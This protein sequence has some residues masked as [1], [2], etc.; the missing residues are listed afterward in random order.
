[1]QIN[2]ILVPVDFSECS[3]NA[4]KI[5]IGFAK[6]FNAKIHMVNAVHVHHPHP[7]FVG[8]SLIDSI[9]LDYENQV[10]D[11]FEELE[12][13][14]IELKDVP[15]EA[16]R[17]I[18]Y[19][20]D[21]IYTESQ[22]KDID[23]IVMGTR[24]EHDKIEHLIG[25]RST[26]IVESS[27]VPVMVIPEEYREFAPKKIG[28]AS[29]LSEIVNFQRLKLIDLF[30]KLYDA[31]VMVFSIVDDPEKLTA[32]DQKHLKEIVKRFEGTNCSARTVQADS[33]TEGI[34][35]FSEKHQLDMLA[36]LPRQRNFFERLFKRSITKNIAIDIKIPLLSFHE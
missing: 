8:G 28:F 5:A 23:L 4:L 14:I 10:K 33:I 24:A 26:D 2:N 13:E 21:A 34:V 9:M 16:D 7:D 12:S 18:S 31:E 36:M 27:E 20:T 30:A 11:S 25:T 29:D 1:M 6:Q 3:K 22:Q 35:Q 19:L 15:H 17:F 32:S